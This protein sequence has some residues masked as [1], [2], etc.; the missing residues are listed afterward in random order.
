MAPIDEEAI[1]DRLTKTC[2]CKVVSRATIKEA[3]ANGAD[4]IEKIKVATGAMT[5]SCKGRKCKER[6][7]ELLEKNN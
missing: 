6:I 4:T 5:G 3:I 7:E 1:K 2:T